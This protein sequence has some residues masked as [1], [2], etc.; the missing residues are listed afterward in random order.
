MPYRVEV[1][2]GPSFVEI[3]YSGIVTPAD[4]DGSRRDALVAAGKSKTSLFLADSTMQTGR[5]ILMFLNQAVD[6]LIA[7][8]VS[9]RIREAVVLPADPESRQ[10]ALFWEAACRNRGVDVRTFADRQG[11]LGWLLR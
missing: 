9:P 3:V 7:A 2:S 8:R 6:A 4:L 11:A 10:S 5:V 1:H